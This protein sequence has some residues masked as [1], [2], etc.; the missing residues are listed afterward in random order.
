[1]YN[2][3]H[4]QIESKGP[5]FELGDFVIKLGSVTMSQNFKGVMVE[6]HIYIYNTQCLAHQII[7]QFNGILLHFRCALGRISTVP[8]SFELLGADSRVYAR[9]HGWPCE[10]GYANILYGCLSRCAESEQAARHL[11]TH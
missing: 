2:A 3:S 10:R 5:R 4:W 11:P 7:N 1:M 9:I 8:Y 6:V